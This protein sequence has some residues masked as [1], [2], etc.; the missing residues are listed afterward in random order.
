MKR[1]E[2][3]V[4]QIVTVGTEVEF[5]QSGPVE[6]L[7]YR[8]DRWARFEIKEIVDLGEDYVTVEVECKDGI[9]S[10]SIEL[11]LDYDDIELAK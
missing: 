10:G 5:W 9:Y 4:G 1:N 7:D 3:A 8:T 6:A 11:D 2:L